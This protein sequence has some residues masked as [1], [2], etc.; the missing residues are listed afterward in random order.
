MPK[1]K[2]WTELEAYLQNHVA[3]T[4]AKSAE[5]ER[6]LAEV[7]SQAV[8]D[9]VYGAYEPTQYDRRGD[10]EGLSDTRNMG[11]TDYGIRDD[12]TVFI[13][14]ENL[15]EGADSL[16]GKYLTDTIVEGIEANWNNSNGVWA[17]PRDFVGETAN[18]LRANPTELMNAFRSGLLA[19]GF[20]IK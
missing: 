14:F 18:R 20:K 12:G 4:I 19:R 3:R 9:V 16:Q 5:V 13:T 8:I 6:V 17:E 7:M 1:F 10:E 15:T 11:I 2:N